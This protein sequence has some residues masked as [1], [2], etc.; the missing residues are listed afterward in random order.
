MQDVQTGALWDAWERIRLGL[1]ACKIIKVATKLDRDQVK[2]SLGM[3][4]EGDFL[5][6]HVTAQNAAIYV[7]KK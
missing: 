2:H 4:K 1:E 6:L 7:H 3:L 5:L